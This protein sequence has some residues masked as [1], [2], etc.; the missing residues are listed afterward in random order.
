M[1]LQLRT[2]KIERLGCE[3]RFRLSI[4][5]KRAPKLRCVCVRESGR[6]SLP[7]TGPLFVL[8]VASS[9]S[10]VV[11]LAPPALDQKRWGLLAQPEERMEDESSLG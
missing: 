3:I 11:A 2:Y 10:S 7:A 6:N 4:S 9:S 5:G 8:A 1:L